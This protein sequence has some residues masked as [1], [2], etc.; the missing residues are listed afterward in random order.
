MRIVNP[1]FGLADAEIAGMSARDIDWAEEPILLF[2]NSKP[3]ATELLLAVAD[4]L[5][6][7]AGFKNAGL[8]SKG[9]AAMPAPAGLM[10]QIAGRHRVALLALA[11]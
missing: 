5:K 7:I 6:T 2:S 11:D 1:A 9:N 4:R 8:V 10:E 3:N